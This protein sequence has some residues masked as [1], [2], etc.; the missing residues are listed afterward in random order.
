ML[1]SPHASLDSR[2]R[3]NDMNS[4]ADLCNQ[5]LVMEA[6][7]LACRADAYGEESDRQLAVGYLN[8]VPKVGIEPTRGSPPNSF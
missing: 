6:S 5:A 3:G 2:L 1:D 8:L 7:T 4:C